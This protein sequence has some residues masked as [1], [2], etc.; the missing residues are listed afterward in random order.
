MTTD[1]YR[2]KATGL[3]RASL[4]GPRTY[5]SIIAAFIPLIG[6]LVSARFILEIRLGTYAQF[7]KNAF[8][9]KQKKL[10][11][12]REEYRSKL[13]CIISQQSH[14]DGCA[15]SFV[16]FITSTSDFWRVKRKR[17]VIMLRKLIVSHHITISYSNQE[18]FWRVLKYASVYN[19]GYML[20]VCVCFFMMYQSD[21]SGISVLICSLVYVICIIT[22]EMMY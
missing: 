6:S 22:L 10:I 2:S 18:L 3:R 12:R 7:I 20:C 5:I 15:K 14:L 16:Y 4:R 19:C 17:E 13:I 9:K 11:Q 1:S 8:L 21:D